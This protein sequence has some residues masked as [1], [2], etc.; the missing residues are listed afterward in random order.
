[1]EDASEHPRDFVGC[2]CHDDMTMTA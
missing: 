1:V 2:S